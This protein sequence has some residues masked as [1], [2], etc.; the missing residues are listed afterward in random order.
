[1]G[2]NRPVLTERDLTALNQAL[3]QIASN[4]S[5][6]VNESLSI[7]HGIN[8]QI[9]NYYDA[10]GDQWGNVVVIFEFG[11]PPN[12]TR[13]YVPAQVTT[14]GPGSTGSGLNATG[15]PAGSFSSPGVPL[16]LRPLITEITQEAISQAVIYDNLLLAH[17]NTV[18]SDTGADQCHGGRSFTVGNVT[19]SLGHVVGRRYI[20]LGIGGTTWKVPCDQFVDD[21]TGNF[22]PPQL[23]RG[24][25]LFASISKK[26]NVAAMGRDDE[27]YCAFWLTDPTGGTSPHT[28]QWE[29][30]QL[31]DG[32]SSTWNAMTDTTPG[33]HTA[34]TTK[35]I[36]YDISAGSPPGS[37]S[38][39]LQSDEGSDHRRL[40]CTVRAKITNQAGSVYTNYCRFY[41][42]DE[43]GCSFLGIITFSDPD[44][45]SS[46]WY[47]VIPGS[48]AIQP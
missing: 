38:I 36:L 37:Y 13:L 33:Y 30:N 12:V 15:N 32:S 10:S 7:A 28:V 16:T 27:Q 18:F 39:K 31:A 46:T 21:G 25:N 3:E 22:G 11:T 43:D 17:A 2:A 20:T 23:M 41:A 9:A 1:M 5:L 8:A 34:V 48:P 26:H 19:D 40:Q 4:L 14:L 29:I 6:H 45:N 24:I 42:N 47:E 44:T 35:A